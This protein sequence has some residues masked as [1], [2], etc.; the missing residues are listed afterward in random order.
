MAF[1][2][3]TDVTVGSVLTASRYNADVVENMT[4]IG[5]AWES[6]TPTFTN[7]TTT[8]GTIDAKYVAA[9]KLH[10]VRLKFTLGASSAVTGTPEFTLP[11]AVSMNAAYIGTLTIG[12]GTFFDVTPGDA[13]VSLVA[14][15]TGS[16]NKARMLFQSITGTTVR[17]G[18]ATASSPFT[19]ASGDILQCQFMFEA[20]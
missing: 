2:I 18:G 19:W 1:V 20:A 16:A 11:N 17:F 6:Y 7:V 10:I 8:G 4:A 12:A 13:Y 14:P 3:P 5:G 15:V 9:G